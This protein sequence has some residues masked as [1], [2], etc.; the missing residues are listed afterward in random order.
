M[1]SPS[2]KEELEALRQSAYK[3]MTDPL[4]R[5]CFELQSVLERQQVGPIIRLMC[6]VILLLKERIE[7]DKR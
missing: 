1:L 6:K 2:E 3:F 5:S 7:N 4:E